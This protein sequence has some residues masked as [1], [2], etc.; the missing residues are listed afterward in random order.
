VEDIQDLKRS[1]EVSFNLVFLGIIIGSLVLS[2]SY[3]YVHD[4]ENLIS[5][6]PAMSFFGYLFAGFLGIIAFINYIKK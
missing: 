6:F 2:A 3:I 5:G 4:H 1:V